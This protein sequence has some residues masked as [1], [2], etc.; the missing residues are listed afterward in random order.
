MFVYKT[1]KR[2]L[3]VFV[4]SA[5]YY[6]GKAL[7]SDELFFGMTWSLFPFSNCVGSDIELYFTIDEL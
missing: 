4:L 7:S 2:T 3:I 5:S 6:I 1:S